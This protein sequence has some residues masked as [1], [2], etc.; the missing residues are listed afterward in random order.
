MQ[1]TT[2]QYDTEL[3]AINSILAAIG[4][5]PI[6][7]LNYENPEVHLIYNLLQESN[8]DVQSEGWVFNT[9]RDY[10]LLP[11]ADGC[12]YI[13]DNILEMDK[14]GNAV[15]RDTNVVKRGGKLYDK[16]NHTYKF[17]G[18]QRLDI[19]WLFPFEDI[20]TVFQRYITYRASS[21]AATQIVTNS[22]LTKLLSQQEA[23]S[24]SACME[25]ECNQGD[26]T[27]F[28][29][30]EYSAYSPYKPYRALFR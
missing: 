16:L 5:A 3:S 13:P 28:G 10:P 6:P 25:Y 27:M 9:E 30:P 18:E 11:A 1:A 4:Q 2:F 7:T 22:E 29:T 17:S 21:R 23:L 26:Y 12:I 19:T 20:P 15:V 8:R 24:R 14:T